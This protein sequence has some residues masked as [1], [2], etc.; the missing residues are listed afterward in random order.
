MNEITHVVK[1]NIIN[2]N[3]TLHDNKKHIPDKNHKDKPP[4]LSTLIQPSEVDMH[5]QVPLT[6]AKIAPSKKSITKIT[7]KN[8]IYNFK[9]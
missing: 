1:S 7:L 6:K 2:V 4:L 8:Q 3:W 5:R 9:K